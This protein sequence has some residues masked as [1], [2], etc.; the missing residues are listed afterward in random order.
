MNMNTIQT[1]LSYTQSLLPQFQNKSHKKQTIQ[2]RIKFCVRQLSNF[3]TEL[4]VPQI[5]SPFL[6]GTF[7][8]GPVQTPYFT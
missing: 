5:S 2:N 1:E 7:L 8:L 4:S 3:P 6:G